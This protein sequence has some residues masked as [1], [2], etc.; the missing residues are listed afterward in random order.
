MTMPAL[1]PPIRPGE[2]A[3]EFTLPAVNHDG[4]VSLADFKGR[5]PVLLALFR[6]LFCPFCRWAL[7]QLSHANE[8]LERMGVKTVCVFG[9]ELENARLYF[10]FR[11][12][13]VLLAADPELTTHRSFG[14]PFVEATPEVM[15]ALENLEINPTGELPAP[16]NIMKIGDELDRLHGYQQTESDRRDAERQWGQL[17]G[18]FLLDE[19]GIVQ[20]VKVECEDGDVRGFGKFPT[21]SELVEA[22]QGALRA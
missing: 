5:Q 8:R 1:R 6:G 9:S 15:A 12:T 20:W 14:L 10:R 2:P 11:P 16:V 19:G 3:P 13:R 22:V 17:K 21:D 18:I 4:T 7:G